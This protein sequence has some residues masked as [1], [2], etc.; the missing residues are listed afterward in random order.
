MRNES[1]GVGL[2]FLEGDGN[3]AATLLVDDRHR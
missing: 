3:A 1:D 2:R